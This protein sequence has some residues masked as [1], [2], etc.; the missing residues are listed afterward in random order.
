MNFKKV[1]FF[2]LFKVASICIP[3]AIGVWWIPESPTYLLNRNRISEALDALRI[4]DREPILEDYFSLEKSEGES[5]DSQSRKSFVSE[6]KNPANY[7]PFL[8]GITLMGFFQVFGF[9]FS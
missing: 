7:K 1:H 5:V 9:Y 4:L 3:F 6:M 2:S 8:C